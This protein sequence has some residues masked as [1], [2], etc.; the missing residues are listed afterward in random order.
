[1]SI[2]KDQR[3]TANDGSLLRR[4]LS[5]FDIE[6][7]GDFIAGYA[8]SSRD[9]V[10]HAVD[11]C[12]RGSAHVLGALLVLD[13]GGRA[14]YVQNNFFGD[15]VNS[16]VA[17]NFQLVRSGS[18]DLLRLESNGGIFLDVEEMRAPQIVISHLDAGIH[19][20]GI[21]GGL[22]RRFAGLAASYCTLPLT[23]VNAPRTVEIPRW[24]T[25]NCAAV[26][27][28]SICQVSCAA[29]D[30]GSS[31]AM[32]MTNADSVRNFNRFS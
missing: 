7:D 22:N 5:H 26:C 6:C 3:L 12:G 10:I 25:E 20:S 29:A 15:A 18:F 17:G 28:G 31:K 2:A 16:K 30:R 1:M 11:S 21:N 9:S 24:R 32:A 4:R 19:G 14:V 27:L 8:G 23:L 13:G